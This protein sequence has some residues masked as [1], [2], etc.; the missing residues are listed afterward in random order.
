MP[1]DAGVP[2]ARGVLL[3]LSFLVASAGLGLAQPKGEA[4]SSMAAPRA[5]VQDTV[6]QVLAVLDAPGLDENQRRTRIEALAFSVFDFET[7]SRLVMARNWKKLDKAQRSVFVQEFKQY[8]SRNYGRR[9]ERYEKAQVEVLGTRSE[10]RRDVTVPV[11]YTHL[12]L[13]TLL[14]V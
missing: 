11:S 12:T 6:E 8:L 3:V 13:P 14:L 9:L 10:P 4:D 7:V 5:V 1:T 2:R